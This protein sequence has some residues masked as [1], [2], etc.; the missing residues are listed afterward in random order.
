M[1][2]LAMMLNAAA[3]EQASVVRE[4]VEA[5]SSRATPTMQLFEGRRLWWATWI[6]EAFF[7]A[8]IGRKPRM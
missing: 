4:I 2:L 1:D 8:T 5:Q 7:S 3:V 6:D